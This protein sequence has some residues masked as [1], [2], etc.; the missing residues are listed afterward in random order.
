MLAKQSTSVNRQPRTTLRRVMCEA[1]RRYRATVLTSC[2]CVMSNVDPT[3]PRNGTDFMPLR[4]VMR[5]ADPTLPRDGTDFMPLRGGAM[6]TRR[7]RVTVLT[8]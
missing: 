7:Y 6:S 4:C 8:S 2:H 1:T 5:D 3:L